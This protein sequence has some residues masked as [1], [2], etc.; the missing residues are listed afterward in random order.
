MLDMI[1]A[2]D[3]GGFSCGE[4]HAIFRPTRPHH[5]HINCGCMRPDCDL[6][7]QIHA[8]GEK[9]LY[10]SIFDLRP[11]TNFIV[12]SSKMLTWQYDQYRYLRS[13]PYDIYNILLWKT[14]EEYA[15]SCW[16]RKKLF[17]WKLHYYNYYRDFS[18]IFENWVSVSYT[19]LV[20]RPNLT[21]HKVCE[22]IGI[23]Y[24]EGKQN[25]WENTRHTLFGNDSAI[26][27]L[28]DSSSREYKERAEVLASIK[29]NI[30]TQSDR[31]ITDHRSI[32]HDTN[33]KKMLPEKVWRTATT[34]NKLLQIHGLLARTNVNNGPVANPVRHAGELKPANL[35][36]YSEKTR[37][38]FRRLI[39]IWPRLFLRS[40]FAINRK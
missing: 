13:K 31:A 7:P 1:L 14:P 37:L 24:F 16:K 17:R 10:Q 15:Y 29:S 26:I 4:V 3:P 6:W 22:A 28:L 19:D 30:E 40:I 18:N 5:L 25:Y 21:I 36:Y 38:F 9:N 12:D 11:E 23:P 32:Y 39:R 33:A 2:N 34:D 20:T 35:L 27:H 8:N